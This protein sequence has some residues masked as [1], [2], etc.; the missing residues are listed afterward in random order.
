MSYRWRNTNFSSN[1]SD[2][3]SQFYIFSISKSFWKTNKTIEDK[4]E[5]QIK[6]L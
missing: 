4:E 5:K 6:E 3:T 1:K 2:R